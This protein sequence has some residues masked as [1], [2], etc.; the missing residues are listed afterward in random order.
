MRALF[1]AKRLL[2]C[3]DVVLTV[4]FPGHLVDPKQA[5]DYKTFTFTR[6]L[7]KLRPDLHQLWKDSW[8]KRALNVPK[9][10]PGL[11][12]NVLRIAASFN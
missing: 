8:A 4:L 2:R 5:A 3:V 12:G 7:L 11:V 9:T 6:R 1:G 10:I